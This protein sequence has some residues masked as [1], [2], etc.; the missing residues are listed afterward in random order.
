MIHH[1]INSVSTRILE[2]HRSNTPSSAHVNSPNRPPAFQQVTND[3]ANTLALVLEND[4]DVSTS[5]QLFGLLLNRDHDDDLEEPIVDMLQG[6][7]V[8]TGMLSIASTSIKNSIIS[9]RK[10]NSQMA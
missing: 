3:V 10:R 8:K 9:A 6:L 5:S 2:E 7:P 1:F 4:A